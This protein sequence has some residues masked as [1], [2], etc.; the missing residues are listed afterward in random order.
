MHIKMLTFDVDGTIV[1][2]GFMDKFWNEVVPRLYAERH[3]LSYDEA[4]GIVKREYDAVGDK[5]LR[6][7]LPDYWFKKFDLGVDWKDVLK[8]FSNELRFYP[9]AMEVLNLLSKKYR[10]VAITNAVREILEFEIDRISH[11]FWKKF[12]CPSDFG[13]IRRKPEIFE[14]VCEVCG[15]KPEEVVHVGDH[16]FFDYEVPKRAGIMA[17]LIDRYGNN[18]GIGD[19]RHLL[20]LIKL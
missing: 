18:G 20:N 11:L 14:R 2:A 16:P 9:D 4:L 17:F 13:D 19:M 1:D 5:D 10:I 12:S 15:V 7:Y 8:S 3:G 6:W